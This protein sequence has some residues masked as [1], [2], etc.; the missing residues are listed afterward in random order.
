MWLAAVVAMVV[1]LGKRR[2]KEMAMATTMVNG[3]ELFYETTGKGDCL[4]LTHGSWT[5][6]TG[7]D[8]VVAGLAERYQV[9][10]W[11]RRGHSRSEAGDGPGSLAEDAVDLAGL[12]EHVSGEPVH[13]AGNSYGSNVTLTLLTQRPDLVVTAAVHE[14]PLWGL[15]EGT[16]DQDLVAELSRA[17]ADLAVVRKLISSGDYRDAAEHFVEHVALGRGTWQQLPEPFRAVLEANAPTYLDELADDTALSIDNAGLAATAVP[18]LLTH[19]TESPKLFPAVIAELVKLVPAAR[20]DFLEG[21]G[22]IPHATHPGEWIA[23]LVAFHDQQR[24]DRR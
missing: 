16:R 23:H 13:V 24:T 2:T 1:S 21:A 6:G 22:H 14:P 17:D 20:V 8:R 5:D 18:L 4:V 9:V 19:G 15:L 3:V 12:I 11:D 7:W 10:V